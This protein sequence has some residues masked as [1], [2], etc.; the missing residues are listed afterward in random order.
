MRTLV[1]PSPESTFELGLHLS[2]AAF[3]GCVL[4]LS[5]PLGAGKTVLAKGFGQGLGV[6]EPV[7]SPTFILA[8]VYER[9]R[10]PFVHVD[11]YRLEEAEEVR[12]AGL[13]DLL[14]GDAA[15]VVEWA[16]RFFET[17]P[18]DRL[19][20]R[21]RFHAGDPGCRVAEIEARGPLHHPLEEAAVPAD[22]AVAGKGLDG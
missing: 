12:G 22:P 5:G 13:L 6:D 7:T 3:P 2:R 19:E 21:L 17:L 1:L 18:A 10:L 20:I 14:G 8:A 9:G 11:F 16:D 4:A 15:A